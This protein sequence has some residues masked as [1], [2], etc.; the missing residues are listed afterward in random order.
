MAVG[1]GRLQGVGE[2]LQYQV[3][4]VASEALSLGQ[5]HLVYGLLGPLALRE[6][7]GYLGE[8]DELILLVEHWP[9]E[10]AGPEARSV[11]SHMP[12]L[13]LGPALF[14]GLLKFP[15]GRTT[16]AVLGREQDGSVL[17][18]DLPFPVA[19]EALGPLV[20]GAH[21]PVGV[22]HEDGV[23]LG[24]L[25]QA[26]EALLALLERL[27]QAPLSGLIVVCTTHVASLSLRPVQVWPIQRSAWK[28]FLRISL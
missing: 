20:P 27:L 14:P 3:V 11:V 16:F 5:A 21:A 10:A 23:V 2:I 6:V 8:A 25:N 13:V 19:E 17:A 4:Q 12:A 22:G 18:D 26:L 9:Y 24:G 28:G 7:A 15:L 1:L